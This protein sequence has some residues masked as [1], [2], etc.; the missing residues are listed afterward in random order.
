ME[1][2]A[3]L[4]KK[5]AGIDVFDMKSPRYDRARVETVAALEPTFAVSISRTSRDLSV[6]RSRRSSRSA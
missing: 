2:K 6:S 1:G 4:F 5:F 3:V